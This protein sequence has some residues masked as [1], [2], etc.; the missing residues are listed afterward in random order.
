MLELGQQ[1]GDLLP[2]LTSVNNH[3]DGAVVQKEF[4]ALESFG[5][6]LPHGLLDDARAGKSD[7]GVGLANVDV[8]KHREAG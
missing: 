2:H 4:T 5:E 7:Q 3:V 1:V 8:S 6:L